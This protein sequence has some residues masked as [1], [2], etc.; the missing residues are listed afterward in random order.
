MT[1]EKSYVDKLEV[2]F[3]FPAVSQKLD[4]SMV[5]LYIRAIED[6]NE[7]YRDTDFVPP[8]ALAALAMFSLSQVSSFPP[9]TIHVTQELEFL[10]IVHRGDTVECSAKISRKQERGK[11]RLMTIDIG[12]ARQNKPVMTGK[13]G[14]ILP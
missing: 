9:G 2:G 14:V 10:D 11:L 1:T 3:E 6:T 12:V 8:T 4:S 13:V 5:D 7:I